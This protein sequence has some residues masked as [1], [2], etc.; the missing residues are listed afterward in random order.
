MLR[1]LIRRAERG[2]IRAFERI[3]TET[4]RW[5]LSRVRRLIGES[6]AEDVL[7]DV[8]LQVWKTLAS[9]DA[10]RGEPLAWMM[11]IARSRALDRLRAERASHGGLTDAPA[12][13]NRPEPSHNAGP[14]ELL[15]LAQSRARVHS[16]LATL[17]EKERLVLGLAYFADLSQSE[18]ASHT[19]M[20]LG[21]VKSV[22]TRS[23]QKLRAVLLPGTTHLG[24]AVLQSVET[25]L[26]PAP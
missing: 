1:D 16:G 2:D 13:F 6:L 10:D 12:E 19:G 9:F 20:P 26:A 7:A 5:M 14:P 4:S 17:S 3:Y 18:I 24:S 23:Q 11:T 22:M 25:M 15:E 21:S 8:Y